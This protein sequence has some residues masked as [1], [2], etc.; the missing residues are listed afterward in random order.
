VP[1][2][3]TAVNANRLYFTAGPDDETEGI[4]GYIVK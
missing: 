1:A 3:A 2:T 4:F